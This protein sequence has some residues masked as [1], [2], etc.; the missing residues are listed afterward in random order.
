MT[1][2]A[3]CGHI[4]ITGASAGIGRAC[5]LQLARQGFSV[6][7]GVR[8]PAEARSLEQAGMDTPIGVRSMQLDVTDMP[9]IRAAEE[10]I[11][12]HA[13]DNG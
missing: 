5:A 12:P 10:E 3:P 4:L 13:G 1:S 6:W 7:A 11:R 2:S 8:T 9:S